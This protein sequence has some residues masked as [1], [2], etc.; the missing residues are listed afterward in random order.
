VYF[1]NH[2]FI[3]TDFHVPVKTFQKSVNGDKILRLTSLRP[4]CR[5]LFTITANVST[6]IILSTRHSHWF[7]VC[8]RWKKL[9]VRCLCYRVSSCISII[10]AQRTTEW[11]AR[12]HDSPPTLAT[13]LGDD[14]TSIYDSI[15]CRFLD[16]YSESNKKAEL[17]LTNPRDASAITVRFI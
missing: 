15:V 13:S 1:I 11:P 4:P 7:A 9:T 16:I 2:F 3:I 14:N 12:R 5:L 8:C 17:S 6:C 10:S